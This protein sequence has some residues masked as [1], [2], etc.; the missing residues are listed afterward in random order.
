MSTQALPCWLH[1]LYASRR[2]FLEEDIDD[3]PIDMLLLEDDSICEVNLPV[4]VLKAGSL[5][6]SHRSS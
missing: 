3:L 2:P 1:V 4:E 6:E 5:T